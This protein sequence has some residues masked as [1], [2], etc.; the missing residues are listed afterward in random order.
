MVPGRQPDTNERW[1]RVNI[2]CWMPKKVAAGLVTLLLAGSALAGSPP[3]DNASEIARY[4]AGRV[5]QNAGDW[6]TAADN[7]GAALRKDPEND[8]LL[9]RTFLL[10]L[11]DGDDAEAVRLARRM[12]ADASYIASILIIADDLKQG[13]AE[14]AAARLATLPVDGLSQ[15]ITPLL[16][17]WVDV[18]RGDKEGAV[19]RLKALK[20][21][22]GFAVMQQLQIALI[23]DLTDDHEAAAL[24]YVAA[25]E[26]G[27]PL[28]LTYL[29]GNFHERAGNRDAARRLYEG[30]RRANPGTLAM[31]ETIA[32]LNKGIVPERLVKDAGTGLGEALY[33]MAAA[34]Q[35]EKALEM[36]L[37][38][39][40]VSLYLDPH[41]PLA[42][43][44]VGDVLATRGQHAAALREYRAVKADAGLLWSAKLRQADTLRQMDR[45]D[46]AAKVLD[47]MA[48]DQPERTD[49]LMQMGDLYRMARQPQKALVAYDRAIARI[50]QPA[51]TDWALF[52]A[53][54]ICLDTMGDWAKAEA[55]MKQALALSPNQASILNYLG[56]S[57][58]DRDIDLEKGR[59]MI[60]QA[61]ALRPKD[62][63]IIDSLGWAKF[64][65][66][67]FHGAVDL[68]E[69]AMELE[70]MD[71]SIS[72][73]LGDA[74]W[75][76]G[77]KQ[78]A[79]FQWSRAA[80]QADNEGLRKSAES[81]LKEGLA[82]P[83]TASV[84]RDNNAN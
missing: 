2:S 79:R 71:P 35:Q 38:Y 73:H 41:Q 74:Y 42:R 47:T 39:G 14:E 62:G 63:F 27:M 13:K 32:R 15:F 17:A 83:R 80:Q 12:D 10:N 1:A 46:D 44:M 23:E 6:G 67:D 28:R 43:L 78:E 56:Y 75:A 53:R 30:Y 19:N 8:A 52:Y 82:T 16:S 69:Q 24:H 57:Y 20:T 18:A 25:G 11:G 77:R 76:L 50:D 45:I 49:A 26:R 22:E 7:L 70:P 84:P 51:P 31:D 34:L 72:D 36:S 60:E 33:E 9:R 68:L 64:K 55:V 5:A 61:L 29:V 59:Q 4:L 54:G 58:V 37:L 66:G 65:Q 48:A 81:K 3:E 40:R 21:H